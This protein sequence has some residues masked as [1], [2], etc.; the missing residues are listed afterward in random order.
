MTGAFG[1]GYA[2]CQEMNNVLFNF[3]EQKRMLL[4]IINEISFMHK[5]MEE[6]FYSFG[7]RLKEP[8]ASFALR[9]AEQMA[10]RNGKTLCEIWHDEARLLQRS[11]ECPKAAAAMLFRIGESLGYDGDKMQIDALRLID[12]ELSEEIENRTRENEDKCKLVRT[13]SVLAGLFCVVLLI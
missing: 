13:L 6:I 11:K 4:Y 9:I 1:F 3:K 8:Y 12:A 2:L 7:G 10:S 5:P